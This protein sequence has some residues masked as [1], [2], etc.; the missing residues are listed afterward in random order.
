MIRRTYLQPA[1]DIRFAS[2]AVSMTLGLLVRSTGMAAG[3]DC[4][5]E[6]PASCACCR[7]VC[8]PTTKQV[9][10][11]KNCPIVNCEEV[12]VPAITLP[13]EPG[14]SPLTF[15]N[16]LRRCVNSSACRGAQDECAAVNCCAACE[17]D[18]GCLCGP[19][20]CGTVR[21]VHVLSK[22]SVDVTMCKTTWEIADTE[23]CGESVFDG[24]TG[25]CN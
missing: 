25:E 8:Y 4:C 12:A 23:P 15:F 19:T 10:E 21:C 17:E 2:L 7:A 22:E 3:T 24:C 1:H 18:D 6:P 9:K 13:W 16:C 14:G 11:K 20:R 5:L